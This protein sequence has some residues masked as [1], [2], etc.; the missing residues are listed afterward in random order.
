MNGK[1]SDAE[2]IVRVVTRTASLNVCAI[3]HVAGPVD[4]RVLRVALNWLQ[5]RHP[6]LKT[7]TDINGGST[8]ILPD[9]EAPLPI[10]LRLVTRQS[11]DDWQIEAQKEL[12]TPLPWARGSLISVVLLKSQENSDI[13]LTLHHVLNDTATVLYLMRDMIGLIVQLIKGNHMPALQVFPERRALDRLPSGNARLMN[14]LLQT[15]ALVVALLANVIRQGPAAKTPRRTQQRRAL[16]KPTSPFHGMSMRQDG[17]GRTLHY[18]M[19]W[20]ETNLFMHRCRRQNTTPHAAIAAAALQAVSQVVSQY[21]PGVGAGM[22]IQCLSAPRIQLLLT[23]HPGMEIA[24]FAHIITSAGYSGAPAHFWDTARHVKMAI[25]PVGY[26]DHAQVSMP[27]PLPLA[28][29]LLGTESSAII[30][31]NVGRALT[32]PTASTPYDTLARNRGLGMADSFG[33]V[34]NDARNHLVISFFYPETVL[35]DE[36]ANNLGAEIVTNLRAAMG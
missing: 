10:P 17:T 14:S 25:L 13:I 6:L 3:A 24:R 28:R 11:D 1:L 15:T 18:M 2:R 30:I 7:R 29:Y 33:I 8:R 34:V 9:A 32:V 19:S 27:L 16:P 22:V 26:P 12:E 31:A 5:K 35:S 23:D 4:E 20:E 21:A 36:R